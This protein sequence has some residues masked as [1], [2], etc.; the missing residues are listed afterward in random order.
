[1]KGLKAGT[2][3]CTIL[4]AFGEKIQ[5]VEWVGFCEPVCLFICGQT[6]FFSK[7]TKS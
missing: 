4:F 2:E 5:K 1:M 3:I 7:Q 6:F